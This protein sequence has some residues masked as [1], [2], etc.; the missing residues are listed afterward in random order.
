MPTTTSP[1]PQHR[2]SSATVFPAA[3]GV[4][5]VAAADPAANA[6]WKFPV[7]FFFFF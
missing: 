4:R 6:K 2:C 1:L 3:A 7:E 5:Q